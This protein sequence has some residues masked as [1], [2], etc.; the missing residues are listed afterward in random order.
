LRYYLDWRA[1]L[2]VGYFTG[3]VGLAI[4][5]AWMLDHHH[6]RTAFALPAIAA[7]L[8][9]VIWRLDRRNRDAYR[10][11]IA[12]GASLEKSAGLID[13]MYGKFED[14]SKTT[15]ISH[16][17]TLDRLFLVAT[18]ILVVVAVYLYANGGQLP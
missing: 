16:S 4:G 5:F 6:A 1:R 11:C 9:W 13:G 12:A 17:R 15:R 14:K 7:G 18:V 8:T 3:L 10:D 2:L